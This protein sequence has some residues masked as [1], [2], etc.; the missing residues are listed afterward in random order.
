MDSDGAATADAVLEVLQLDPSARTGDL[1][2][3]GPL[4]RAGFDAFV[5]RMDA[6][7]K[8]RSLALARE[9]FAESPAVWSGFCL[10]GALRRS[11]A[12]G[13]EGP[14]SAAFRS[15]LTM[16]ETLRETYAGDPTTQLDITQRI[17][18]LSFGFNVRSREQVALGRAL[19]ST[20]NDAAQ[21][22]GLHALDRDHGAAARLFGSLLD[23]VKKAPLRRPLQPDVS[24]STG[25][26]DESV[27]GASS[28]E[29]VPSTTPQPEAVAW[30]LRGHALAS[31]EL[32]RGPS[33]IQD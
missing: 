16:L 10:E 21:I 23:R 27:T 4:L 33:S 24:T 3:P 1:A 18:I 15:A 6:F 2:Q 7:D 11:A 22:A 25:E 31:L 13:D 8:D 20:G 32:L 28:I 14:N 19:A 30:A 5:E 26:D 9:L 12:A 29:K 17:A